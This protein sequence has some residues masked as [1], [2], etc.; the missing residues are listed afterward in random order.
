MNYFLKAKLPLTSVLWSPLLR[1]SDGARQL[2]W[3]AVSPHPRKGVPQGGA[4]AARVPPG[5]NSARTPCSS[6]G[7]H[8]FPRKHNRA[9]HE[10][11][12]QRVPCIRSRL[13]LNDYNVLLLW[14][15]RPW[16]LPRQ[17]QQPEQDFEVKGKGLFQVKGQHGGKVFLFKPWAWSRDWEHFFLSFL[18]FSSSC[19]YYFR[20]SLFYVFPKRSCALW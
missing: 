7:T 9:H 3:D 4:G 11:H 14:W 16:R 2:V 1:C 5:V 10:A 8:S 13:K 20:A 6:P 12:V 19:S 18:S 17:N 15:N